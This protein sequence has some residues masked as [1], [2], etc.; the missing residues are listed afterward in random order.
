[1]ERCTKCGMIIERELE[2]PDGTMHIVP[3]S[4]RCH[5]EKAERFRDMQRQIKADR[6][7]DITLANRTFE[8]DDGH[9]KGVAGI[10]KNYADNFES[11]RQLGKGLMLYGKPGTGKT[12]FAACIA[13][14]LI[15]NGYTAL[16]TSFPRLIRGDIRTRDER[17]EKL[18][19]YDLLVIDDLGVERDTDFIAE[20]VQEIIDERYRTKKPIIVTTNL[21]LS[22]ITGAQ[23]MHK[24]RAYSRIA[25]MCEF[26]PVDG[27]DMREKIH[28]RDHA[29][30]RNLLT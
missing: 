28:K 8:K 10:C 16:I 6:F 7:R 19:I 24:R 1:M 29:A 12:F 20:Q 27:E 18:R 17:K 2:W 3:C 26:I 21:T 9:N 4:C 23:D 5:D 30:V 25:E 22:E 13:N 15:D 14:R 11:I